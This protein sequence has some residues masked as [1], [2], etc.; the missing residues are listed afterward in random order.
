MILMQGVIYTINDIVDAPQDRLHPTKKKRPIAN[1]L[2]SPATAWIFATILFLISILT[3]SLVDS[4]LVNIDIAILLI[5]ILY[6][7]RPFRFKDIKYL[8]IITAASNFPLRVMVG[9]FLFEPYNAARLNFN[10]DITSTQ[11]QG[12]SIQHIVFNSA[13]RV[14]EISTRFS[15]ITTSFISIML[16]TFFMAIFLMSAKRISEKTKHKTHETRSVLSKY[17]LTTLKL[18]SIS[19]IIFITI[20]Y[21]LLAWSLKPL[22]LLLTPLIFTIFYWYYRDSLKITSMADTPE[23]MLLK[24]KVIMTTLMIFLILCALILLL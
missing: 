20:S 3:A 9:W 21:S 13:P 6:S 4:R 19:S 10:Y 22:L 23:E 17:S 11:I 1:K 7:V 8:D 24:N 16:F 2:I 18:I 12:E 14:L 15:T 5:N